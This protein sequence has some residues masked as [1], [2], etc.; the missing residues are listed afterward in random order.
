MRSTFLPYLQKS[1]TLLLELS[2]GAAL[3]VSPGCNKPEIRVP[4]QEDILLQYGD[5]VLTMTDVARNIPSGLDYEDSCAL[6]NALQRSWLEEQLLEEIAEEN[7]GNDDKIERMVADYRRRLL[8][9]EYRKRMR[10]QAAGKVSEDSVKSFYDRHSSQYKLSSPLVKGVY[11]KLPA[12]DSQIDNVRQWMRNPNEHNLDRLEKY[13]YKEAMQ[14]DYFMDSWQD[15]DKLRSQIPYHF[16]AADS[17]VATTKD[18]ETTYMGSTYIFHISEHLSTDSPMPY[19]IAAVEIKKSLE[20]SSQSEY[21][22]AI[23]NSLI[24]KALKSGKLKIN[25]KTEK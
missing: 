21:E 1:A 8:I 18:F 23:F 9:A 7:L 6:A 12:N 15:W 4:L 16:P 20:E 5:S 13:A 3:L 11:I 17:F 22:D 25:N 24:D 2:F 19:E 14:Y 10:A